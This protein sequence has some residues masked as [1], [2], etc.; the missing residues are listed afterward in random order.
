[1]PRGSNLRSQP[2]NPASPQVYVV[3]RGGLER[4]RVGSGALLCRLS[5]PLGRVQVERRRASKALV[6]YLDTDKPEDEWIDN[7]D[8]ARLGSEEAEKPSRNSRPA[9]QT[10]AAAPDSRP[11]SVDP[12]VGTLPTHEDT[13]TTEG[14]YSIRV[15]DHRPVSV[16]RNVDKV[17]FGHWQI[18]TWYVCDGCKYAF[19]N[20]RT[21][22]SPPIRWPNQRR[23][24]LLETTAWPSRPH[25]NEYRPSTVPSHAHM[26]ELQ[27]C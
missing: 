10:P 18:K 21:G 12:S 7:S 13:A 19:S 11:S 26:G 22:T 24:T 1:M 4:E 15:R 23:T 8:L 25:P 9:T 14:D 5:Y 2:V 27:I 3:T 16:P 20:H 17:N 6:K